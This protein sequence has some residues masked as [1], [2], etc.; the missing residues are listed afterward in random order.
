MGKK[1]IF[2]SSN[3]NGYYRGT[4]RPRIWPIL[5]IFILVAGTAL[6]V[7]IYKL[8]GEEHFTS[9]KPVIKDPDPIETPVEEVVVEIDPAELVKESNHIYGAKD[10]AYSTKDVRNWITGTEPYTGEKIA[11]L[12][13]DDGPSP[14]NTGRLLDILKEKDAVAT[15]FVIG[16]SI[17]KNAASGEILNR[18]LSEGHSIALHSYTHVY[19]KLYPGKTADK[20]YILEELD[21][22][23]EKI[24]ETT[25]KNTFKS[26]VF[27]YPGGHMS[28]GGTEESDAFLA[29]N[30]VEYIDWNAMNGDSEP[31][32]RRPKDPEALASFVQESLI[33][34]KV[35][36]VM[37]ILMHD[38]ENKGMTAESLPMIIDTL[39]S[40]GYKFGILK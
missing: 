11:F 5:L 40:Q 22:L 4:R 20:E 37:V 36:D 28:W 24:R 8:M 35:K 23:Q 39:K 30:G 2:N 15:F 27:R 17:E 19:E 13:F 34:S 16:S 31:T 38:A 1:N 18:V 7:L 14:S 32:A 6:G 29:E 12:T 33:Y 10:Y 25:G 9:N 26:H 21:R 3:S